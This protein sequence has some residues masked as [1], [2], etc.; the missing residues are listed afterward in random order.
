LVF[1]GPAFAQAT[2][3]EVRD[4]LLDKYGHWPVQ[5][6]D[7][8]VRRAL[9]VE[10]VD[11]AMRR[12]NK[13]CSVTD[14]VER[15]LIVRGARE[16]QTLALRTTLMDLRRSWFRAVELQIS[17]IRMPAAMAAANALEDGKSKDLTPDQVALILRQVQEA[18]GTLANLPEIRTQTL[19]AFEMPVPDGTVPAKGERLRPKLVV[20]GQILPLG[21]VGAARLDLCEQKPRNG[22]EDAPA[23][24]CVVAM[25]VGK[26]IVLTRIQ[27]EQASLL[28]VRLTAA[29][30]EPRP[31]M[32]AGPTW[33]GSSS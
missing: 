25:E 23:W 8:D 3:C 19:H 27:G 6:Q 17:L 26:G 22:A 12:K 33:A 32:S 1:A 10:L 11:A 13:E 30:Q 15:F 14:E 2:V 16:E 7:A 9:L 21:D 31:Q 4:L 29:T 24:S 20:R 5:T 28:W 18:H